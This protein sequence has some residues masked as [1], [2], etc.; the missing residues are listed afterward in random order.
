LAIIT[1]LIRNTATLSAVPGEEARQLRGEKIAN[2]W[3]IWIIGSEEIARQNVYP[4]LHAYFGIEIFKYLILQDP[5][6]DYRSCDFSGYEKEI[7]YASSYLDATSTD[8]ER[9][10]KRNG[11]LI[12]WH[13]W[14][15]PALSAYATI[16]HYEKVKAVDPDIMDYMRL[17]LLPGV[18][19]CG[20]GDGPSQVDWIEI[21]RD[22]VENNNPPVRITA[23][24]TVAGESVITRP[25]FPY[26][27]QAM[28]NGKGDPD[29]ESSYIQK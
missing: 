27:G 15:D 14:N 13:G 12:L 17:F 1:D 8:Y 29:K 10:K 28:Y 4:S 24:K 3:D 16:E 20:G 19:H 21:I 6:W 22:W 7:K 25:L 18:L 2:G 11:K 26:P 5:G 23:V 9:F